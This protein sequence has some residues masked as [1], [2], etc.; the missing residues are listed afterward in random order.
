MQGAS[1]AAAEVEEGLRWWNRHYKEF[2]GEGRLLQ[3]SLC[4]RGS[5]GNIG[6]AVY[7][8]RTGGGG[9]RGDAGRSGGRGRNSYNNCPISENLS[10]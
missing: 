2:N 10:G 3:V 8:I 9:D 7:E 1:P 6:K 5:D 4:G